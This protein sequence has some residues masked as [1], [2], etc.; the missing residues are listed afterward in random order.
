MRNRCVDVCVDSRVL[1]DCW[2]WQYSRSHDMLVALEDLFWATV[3]LNV[4]LCL[5]YVLSRHNPSP[6]YLSRIVPFLHDFGSLS[7]VPL[8]VLGAIHV[9]LWRSTQMHSMTFN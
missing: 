6:V 5:K 8:V 7:N 1:L 2:D 3:A 4:A 9:I